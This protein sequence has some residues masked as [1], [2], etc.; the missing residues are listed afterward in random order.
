MRLIIRVTSSDPSS[1]LLK[2]FPRSGSF[3]LGNKSKSGGL[4]SGLHGGWGSTCHP[5]FSK[6][7][8]TA[9]DAWGRALSCKMRTPAANMADFSGES[10]DSKH[11]AET[12]CSM[13]LLQWTSE[14]LC[15]YHLILVISHNHH[16]LNFRLLAVTFFRARSCMLPWRGLR[17]QLFQNLLTMFHLRQQFCSKTAH[18]HRSV[19][20]VL[21]RPSCELLS[22]LRS[23]DAEPTLQ[24]LFSSAMFESRFWK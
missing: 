20:A 10:L 19:P 15:C 13:T 4:M 16:E 8:D 14:A 24:R 23:A 21:L 22:V 7:S 17:F 18:L 3:N 9:P 2:R 12:F 6:I 5:Y 1:M 11:L